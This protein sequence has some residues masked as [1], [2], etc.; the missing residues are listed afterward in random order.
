MGGRDSRTLW[1]N[2]PAA[3]VLLCR[4]CHDWLEAEPEEARAAGYRLDVGD[5][6]EDVLI[7]T[8]E[9]VWI[10]LWAG[11][12]GDGLFRDPYSG[13]LAPYRGAPPPRLSLMVA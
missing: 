8:Y 1:V 5:L 10:R 3:L 12:D 11:P 9:R 2:D 4:T 13:I 7:W 6:P